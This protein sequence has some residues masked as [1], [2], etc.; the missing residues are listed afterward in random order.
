M[1]I[2]VPAT[3]IA[4]GSRIFPKYS[5]LI[6]ESLRGFGST[7]L[8]GKK[9]GPRRVSGK[10]HLPCVKVLWASLKKDTA[11]PFGLRG[12]KVSY[13]PGNDALGVHNHL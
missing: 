13:R 4:N 6:Y 3:V 11:W 12:T 8:S 9:I 5:L 2:L 1:Y 7:E 10:S